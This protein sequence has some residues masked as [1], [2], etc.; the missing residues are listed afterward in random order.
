MAAQN[1]EFVFDKSQLPC[2]FDQDYDRELSLRAQFVLLN[3]GQPLPI[4]VLPRLSRPPKH[5][6]QAHDDELTETIYMIRDELKYLN[7]TGRLD[8]NCRAPCQLGL[9]KRLG[10]RWAFL[11]IGTFAP[12]PPNFSFHHQVAPGAVLGPKTQ[13]DHVSI[14]ATEIQELTRLITQDRYKWFLECEKAIR[15]R[16]KLVET[17]ISELELGMTRQH[18]AVSKEFEAWAENIGDNAFVI[19]DSFQ[20]IQD[21]DT[22]F[23][24]WH[25]W[26]RLERQ[27]LEA[28]Q[29]LEL[30]RHA[31]ESLFCDI[32]AAMTNGLILKGN[33]VR[34]EHGKRTGFLIRLSLLLQTATT[35]AS[36]LGDLMIVKDMA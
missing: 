10:K 23:C 11:H 18:N 31:Q 32:L 26:F 17:R 14:A 36:Q 5:R 15:D 16:I 22:D 35:L 33:R 4:V 29:S 19:D 25:V 9:A 24:G 3:V 28:E 7:E 12:Y 2:V 27:L 21:N 30:E 1:R 6:K 13:E 34:A 8:T 20:R